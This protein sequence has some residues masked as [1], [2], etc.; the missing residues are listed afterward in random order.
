MKKLLPYIYLCLSFMLLSIGILSYQKFYVKKEYLIN[1]ISIKNNTEFLNSNNSFLSDT[2]DIANFKENIV[3]QMQN[4]SMNI[5][6][7]LNFPDSTKYFF[8]KIVNE[9]E[10]YVLK[11]IDKTKNMLHQES[12]QETGNCLCFAYAYAQTMIEGVTHNQY[13]GR[14]WCDSPDEFNMTVSHQNDNIQKAF[15]EI[16]SGRPVIMRG[17][18]CG[19]AGQHYFTVVGLTTKSY[20][21]YITN[22]KLNDAFYK[23]SRNNLIK[24][25]LIYDPWN[26]DQEKGFY[27]MGESYSIKNYCVWNIDDSIR[28]KKR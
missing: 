24:E 23:E 5:G 2:N 15:E 8:N 9:K 22:G 17:I 7:A 6:K 14:K 12:Y 4:R 19:N 3:E 18:G 16:L 1:R 26:N 21:K 10:Y 13:A 25:L 11:S 20:K 28:F 27:N